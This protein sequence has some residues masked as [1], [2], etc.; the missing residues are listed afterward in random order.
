MGFA[1]DA[2]GF[3]LQG[4]D[5][6]TPVLESAGGAYRKFVKQ[7]ETSNRQA[8]KAVTGGMGKLGDLIEQFRELPDEAVK[9][10]KGA[11]TALRTRIKPI[12]QPINVVFS[13]KSRREISNAIGA[14]V[15][16]A[17]SGVKIRMSPSYPETP[18]SL[19]NSKNLR[20]KYSDQTQPPDMKGK[21]EPKKFKK[22]GLVEGGTPGKD[23]VLSLLEP[24]EFVLP[25]EIVK[26]LGSLRGEKGQ[27]ISP[28]S[29]AESVA[30]IDN[31]G[32]ALGKLK[33]AIDAGMKDGK[34]LAMFER[35]LR[36]MDEEVANLVQNSKAL[37][38]QTQVRLAP[39]VR[40]LKKDM[41]ALRMA[42][43]AVGKT[44]NNLLS[45]ILGPARFI[46]IS[47]AAE[48]IVD[49]LS[50]LKDG[51][52]Q[53]FDALGGEQIE[54]FTT[55]VNQMNTRLNL[56]RD[57]LRE[58]K[59]AAAD[60]ADL[61]DLN[62]NEMSEALE[63]MTDAGMRNTD[64]MLRLAPATTDFSR[65][66]RVSFDTSSR[67][68]YR[69]ADAYGFTE[70]QVAGTFDNIRMFQANSAA[71]AEQLTSDM[72]ET[73][74]S[75]GPALL[76]E[77]TENQQKILS[78]FARLGASLSDTWTGETS[79]LQGLL[80]RAM[81]GEVEAM[82]SVSQIFGKTQEQLSSAFRSGDLTGILD[83]LAGQIEM[84]SSS[85]NIA[86]LNALRQSIGFE[87]TPEQFALLGKNIDKV[88]GH[89]DKLGS[90][91]H[92][93]ETMSTAQAN[94]NEAADTTRTTYEEWSKQF[95]QLAAVEIPG[96]GVSLGQ[97]VDL[98]K[99]FNVT[100]LLSVGYLA[101]LGVQAAVGTAKGLMTLGSM[102]GG[103]IGKMGLFGGATKAATAASTVAG[104]ASTAAAGGGLFTGMAAGMTA[105][106]GGVGTLGA[107]LLSP[108]GIAFTVSLVAT[109]LALGGALRLASPAIEV[110][111]N[112]A[113]AAMRGAV[114][115]FGMFVPVA[116][117]V[118]DVAG[119]VL[120]GT[121][122]A[123]VDVFRL[124]FNADASQLALV[125]PALFGIAGGLGAVA[126]AGA[127]LAAV[128]IGQGVLS[129]LTGGP[130]DVGSGVFG[131]LA[132]MIGSVRNLKVATPDVVR[133]LTA[134]VNGLGGFALAYARLVTTLGDL[135]EGEE[136]GPRMSKLGGAFTEA[137]RATNLQQ[138][139][140]TN[141]IA[142][143]QIEMLVQAIQS[144]AKADTDASDRTNALLAQILAALQS[145]GEAAPAAVPSRA[146]SRRTSAAPSALTR[147]VAEF[148]H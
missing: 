43:E 33:V 93:I 107:V 115:A 51:G 17:L 108:A 9:G 86:G 100:T 148:G 38:Y 113:M 42:E 31:L 104:S 16:K 114:E 34:A 147:D 71:N 62:I 58:F 36:E 109:L 117:K 59:K 95:G 129:F 121:L 145:K 6:L 122:S 118:A 123:V 48:K 133:D 12:V 146:P 70:D 74:Q 65:S 26:G 11:L 103:V 27:F 25:K 75:L 102:L 99:E 10:Y 24:G 85:N 22:G 30:K 14:A 41:D 79:N 89:L 119:A 120:L 110:F 39:A 23:S 5:Q 68:A 84:L 60:V 64:M 87:G 44:S 124:L 141:A 125:A 69:L 19:F 126:T 73:M 135:P 94:L 18:L 138:P 96:L 47:M 29:Y 90:K 97:V 13:V 40:D 134:S 143:S 72:L 101:K 76:N 8:Y 88:N 1:K 136:I 139:R 61:K 49:S 52:L 4:E 83:G 35:G 56:S 106:A 7:I 37:S 54:S 80:G 91:Q 81:G 3:Y 28:K 140:A 92:T 15:S 55:N 144:S 46:A 67:A 112:V 50:R 66:A 105:L 53:A 82:Q 131:L 132:S 98:G 128:Q 21:L 127:A 77:S 2:I 130:A 45:K 137:T 78:N 57:E 111:G 32:K 20:S 63:G 116:L 142:P